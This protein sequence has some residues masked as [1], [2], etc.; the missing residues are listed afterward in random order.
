MCK[1]IIVPPCAGVHV[2]ISVTNLLFNLLKSYSQLWLHTLLWLYY[3]TQFIHGGGT[4]IRYCKIFLWSIYIAMMNISMAP[5]KQ[6][7]TA[8][9]YLG[10][11]STIPLLV[12]KMAVVFQS[13]KFYTFLLVCLSIL[14]D[15][16]P[17]N[18]KST[19]TSYCSWLLSCEYYNFNWSQWTVED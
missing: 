9:V 3:I 6:Q 7:Y 16:G 1:K 8:A 4:L 5:Y 12:W 10:I 15:L 13:I 18:M 2:H 17:D 19:Y 11:W 14:S